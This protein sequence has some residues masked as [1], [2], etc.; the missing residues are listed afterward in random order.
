[1][2]AIITV[3]KSFTNEGEG[4]QGFHKDWENGDFT[5]FFKVE[6]AYID[7]LAKITEAYGEDASG[8]SITYTIKVAK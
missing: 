1:M 8:F 4:L 2:K 7:R 5:E 3:S 6:G